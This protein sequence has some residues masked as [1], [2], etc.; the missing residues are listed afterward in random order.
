MDQ[1]GHNCI[2][3]SS[4]LRSPCAKCCPPPLDVLLTC[5]FTQSCFEA[6]Q[7]AVEQQFSSGQAGWRSR[8]AVTLTLLAGRLCWVA[9]AQQWTDGETL[10]VQNAPEGSSDRLL[11]RHFVLFAN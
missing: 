5:A 6:L 2:T 9:P 7:E 8:R 4:L 10:H 11:T 1:V 3:S